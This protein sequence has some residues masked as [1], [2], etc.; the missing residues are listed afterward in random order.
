M[1]LSTIRFGLHLQS[2][3]AMNLTET[4]APLSTWRHVLDV[5][6]QIVYRPFSWGRTVGRGGGQLIILLCYLWRGYDLYT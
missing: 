2:Y 1:E 4:E 5:A 6:P 3:S